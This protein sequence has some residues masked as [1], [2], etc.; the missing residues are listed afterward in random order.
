MAPWIGPR[1]GMSCAACKPWLHLLE[2]ELQQWWR[3]LMATN[4]VPTLFPCRQAMLRQTLLDMA[5]ADGSATA[6]VPVYDDKKAPPAAAPINIEMGSQ[7]AHE[8]AW[9]LRLVSIG[10][11]LMQVS[12]CPWL[13]TSR[14]TGR[15]G[16]TPH[17]LMIRP[18]LSR[19][20]RPLEESC[21]R[22]LAWLHHA[23]IRKTTQVVLS[24]GQASDAVDHVVDD[25]LSHNVYVTSNLRGQPL[26]TRAQAVRPW[27]ESLLY[28]VNSCP[29]PTL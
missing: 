4:S 1:L 3:D 10:C 24:G 19:I 2:W 23:A 9:S 8:I 26:A 18:L 15:L 12:P 22:A 21:R 25:V 13:A 6:V 17:P 16:E 11:V 7:L 5:S 20:V 29:G 27:G 14:A 28:L